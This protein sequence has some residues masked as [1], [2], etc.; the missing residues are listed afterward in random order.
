MKQFEDCNILV[1]AWRCRYLL[2]I[3][4]NTWHLYWEWEHI[5]GNP[6]LSACYHASVNYAFVKMN[7]FRPIK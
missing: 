5:T 3:P 4:K 2:A 6:N 7:Y 1:K